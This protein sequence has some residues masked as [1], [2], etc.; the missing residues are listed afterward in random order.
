MGHFVCIRGHFG[1]KKGHFFQHFQKCPGGT[2]TGPDL[3][4][5][6]QDPQKPHQIPQFDKKTPHLARHM[7]NLRIRGPTGPIWQPSHTDPQRMIL[8]VQTRAQ[9]ASRQFRNPKNLLKV[10]LA[11]RKLLAYP[12]I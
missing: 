12:E 5:M 2:F 8:G 4:Q 3:P 11:A 1:P 10:V 6:V 9:T 7:A